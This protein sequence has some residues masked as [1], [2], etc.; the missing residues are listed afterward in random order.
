MVAE[1]CLHK[2]LN[3]VLELVEDTNIPTNSALE[4]LSF[5][6]NFSDHER[7]GIRNSDCNAPCMF[8]DRMFKDTEGK[9]DELLHHLLLE[10][11]LV[12]ADV[13]KI[14]DLKRYVNLFLMSCNAIKDQSKF[15]ETVLYI[16]N[17]ISIVL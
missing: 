13:S 3:L 6:E 8:C 5:P 11:Q 12:I 17:S 4:P 15:T 16:V 14:P 7:R 10:H 9:N 1:K 2:C